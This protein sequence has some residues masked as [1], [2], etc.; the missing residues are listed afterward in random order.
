MPSKGGGREPQPGGAVLWSRDWGWGILRGLPALNYCSSYINME[1]AA[2]NSGP[3]RDAIDALAAAAASR[4]TTI[5]S[6]KRIRELPAA[7][8]GIPAALRC[9]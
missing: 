2:I 8:S 4:A 9:A 3:I 1:K 6:A 5:S 7:R